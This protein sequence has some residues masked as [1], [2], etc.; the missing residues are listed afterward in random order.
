LL[1]GI[2][3][4]IYFIII[5]KRMRKLILFMHT[6]LDGFVAG[7][8]G[9]MDWINVNEEIF[10]FASDQTTKADTAVYGR[11]TYEMMQAYWPTAGDQ[12]QASR[13][14][15]EHSKWYNEVEKVVI[16][17]SMKGQ[18]LPKTTIVSDDLEANINNL[19]GKPGKNMLMFGSPGAAHALMQ[20]DLIDEFWLF[21]N[22]IILGEGIPLFSGLKK[23]VKLHLASTKI[24]SFGVAC[25]NY[26][27]I[28]Q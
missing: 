26:E 7:P 3:E 8:S 23:R 12:P 28:R 4:V 25:L 20:D 16:S 24:F 21:I 6:T 22:P 1:Q 17:R 14:D 10:D 19:K 13:H 18:Q 27:R 9:E 15:V 5:T 2:L 11:K